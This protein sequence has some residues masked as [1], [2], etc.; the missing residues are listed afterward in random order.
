MCVYVRRTV[1][2]S[3]RRWRH[4]RLHHINLK[5]EK[6]QVMSTEHNKNKVYRKKERPVI[7]VRTSLFFVSIIAFESFVQLLSQI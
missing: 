6:K 7:F 2:I 3:R 1:F 5:S 4:I